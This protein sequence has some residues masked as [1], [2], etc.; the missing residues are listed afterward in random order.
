MASCLALANDRA[1][2][3]H[4]GSQS[5]IHGRLVSFSSTME[6]TVEQRPGW[7]EAKRV[8]LTLWASAGSH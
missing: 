1:D 3:A 2:V 6:A 5:V 7:H 8:V 4:V